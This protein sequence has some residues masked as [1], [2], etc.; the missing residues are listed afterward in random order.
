LLGSPYTDEEW[1]NICDSGGSWNISCSTSLSPGN[2]FLR[3]FGNSNNNNWE[4]SCNTSDLSNCRKTIGE[5]RV[6]QDDI[7]LITGK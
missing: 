3:C 1:N 5:C 4:L 7:W 2:D 6:K